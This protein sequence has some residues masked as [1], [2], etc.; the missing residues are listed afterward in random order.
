M[1]HFPSK[2]EGLKYAG[3]TLHIKRATL[4]EIYVG[5]V[6]ERYINFNVPS[7]TDADERRFILHFDLL[8]WAVC[9]AFKKA[10]LTLQCF[11]PEIRRF[12]TGDLARET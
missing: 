5:H 4:I 8:R 1:P 10:P 3:I 6:R 9:R 12:V 11:S 7:K 2:L